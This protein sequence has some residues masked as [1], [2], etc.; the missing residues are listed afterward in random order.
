MF[1][2]TAY[3]AYYTYIGLYLHQRS[4]EIIT[5]EEVLI[6]L[7][8][9][10][11]G[12]TFLLG[13]WRYFSKFLP[14][15]WGRSRTTG[16]GYIFKVIAC[17][18]LGISL[19]QIGSHS[20]VKNFKRESWSSNTYINSRFQRIQDSY[21]VS[22]VFDILTRSAEELSGFA[23]KVVDNLFATG[24][25]ELKTPGAFYKAILYAGS[26]TIEDSE[27]QDQIDLY[28]DSCFDKVLPLMIQAST[29]EKVDEFFVKNGL[30]DNELKHIPLTLEM[31]GKSNCL[32]L[33]N[34]VRSS[35]TD[36]A[37]EKGANFTRF[38]KAMGGYYEISDTRGKNLIVSSALLNHYRSQT[39]DSLG[40]QKG[41]EVRGSLAKFFQGTSRLLSFDGVLNFF[42]M[43]NQVGAA[44]TAGRAEKFS[45][46]LQRAPHIKGLVKMFLIFLFPWLVFFIIAGR[47]KI[48]I[49]WFAI[50]FSVLLWTPIWTLL[51]HLMTS[52]AMSTEMLHE[53][54]KVGDGVSLYSAD[55]ISAK[56]YQFYAIYSWLQIIV[57]PLP[58]L[59]LSYGL[60]TS[61]L[62][63]SQG[64]QA[65]Q[66]VTDAKDVGVSAATGGAPSAAS[67][68]IKK[69]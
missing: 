4:I 36:Y 32:L 65:P 67:T 10:I 6:A 21:E 39:E 41:S 24:N 58:T 34:A 68:T 16:I 60:F 12:I 2:T 69:V 43:G 44:L 1:S 46:Y 15:S 27:L 38:S 54:G 9:L 50:Y 22:M 8:I 59:I 7:L 40:T 61:F 64:E 51:Y 57:G 29:E 48:L 18:L 31:G 53:W 26:L 3:E 62:T 30:I 49:A 56:L 23:S 52:I 19:L 45:E 47:W 13:T 20:D 42:G 25:S 63:D 5:S 37:K 35:L 14:H 55:F 17:F 33:K 11:L 28:T 66:I